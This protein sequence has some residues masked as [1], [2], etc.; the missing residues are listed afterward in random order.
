MVARRPISEDNTH[1]TAHKHYPCFSSNDLIISYLP[2]FSAFNR[3]IAVGIA[4]GAIVLVLIGIFI[5]CKIKKKRSKDLEDDIED[6][7]DG[8]GTIDSRQAEIPGNPLLSNGTETPHNNTTP[9]DY[10]VNYAPR[11]V[12]METLLNDEGN[13]K[14]NLSEEEYAW[15]KPSKRKSKGFE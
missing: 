9:N 8:H 11:P 5:Y 10:S 2:F 7:D 1:K 14:N 15:F 4:I 13:I 3:F 12:A 6:Y